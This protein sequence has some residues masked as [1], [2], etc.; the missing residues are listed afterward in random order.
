MRLDHIL[1]CFSACLLLLCC[2]GAL[3][4]AG[5]PPQQGAGSPLPVTRL[6]LSNSCRQGCVRSGERREG[7]RSTPN[8]TFSRMH[9]SVAQLH[10][11]K[12]PRRQHYPRLAAP[13]R[14]D[15]HP[16]SM[17]AATAMDNAG[18]ASS[19]LVSKTVFWLGIAFT[20]AIT[21]GML[22][23]YLNIQRGKRLERVLRMTEAKF[24]QLFNCAGDA[25]YI[26]DL[27]FRIIEVNPA[28]CKLMGYSHDQ[29][30]GLTLDRVNA[31]EQIPGTR[32]R[33]DLLRRQGS[34]LYESLQLTGGG[35][36]IPVEVSATLIEY[37]DEPAVLSIVRDISLRK[38]I[39][40]REKTRLQILEQMATGA[41]LED[42][43]AYIVRFV[44]QESPGALCS[45]LL[46]N[47][48]G[49]QLLA[50]AAPSLP[51]SYNRAVN[52]LRIKEGMGSCG[53]AAYL[54]QRVIVADIENHPYWKGFQPARD[55]GLRACWSEPVLSNEGELLGTF[56]VY[57]R[58]C[59]TPSTEELK[60]IESAAHMSSIAI[61]RVRS[62]ESRS[63]L[64]LQMRQMQKIEAVGQ[65]AAGLAHDFNN[66][67]TPIFVYADMVRRSLAED[68]PNRNRMAGIVSSAGKAANLTRQ[69]LSFG[70][71]QI[72]KKENLELNEVIVSLA[73]LLQR[74]IRA[75]VDLRTNLTPSGTRVLADRGQIE[76]ILVNLAVNAQDA[77]QGNGQ[78]IIETA[79][80]VLD[81]EFAKLNPGVKTG[82]HILLTF[83]DDGCGMSEEV[84]QHMFEP[85]YTTKSQGSGTG[86]G[87]A[88]VYGIVKQHNGYI[89][90]QS[91]VGAGTSLLIYLP[92]HEQEAVP[93]Q[94]V[95]TVSPRVPSGGSDAAILVVDDNQPIREMAAELLASAGYRVLVAETPAR[96]R[97]MVAARGGSLD[98]LVTDVVMPQMSGPELYRELAQLCPGL[99]VLYI[100]GYTFD[101][102]L[103]DGSGGEE[104]NFLPK[105]FNC[106]QLLASVRQ[107]L[108]TI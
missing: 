17:D 99:S 44:E 69:L 91:R 75:N 24:R 25:I 9:P 10:A 23:L 65:L 59:R 1:K 35:E 85:F 50:G 52:G 36:L 90:V 72:L 103:H 22:V 89:K 97:E 92:R 76:Q 104:A 88:T 74:T 55:A 47:E 73:D 34:A 71:K 54:R 101:L 106:E 12:F 41:S 96:A 56:A 70:R 78:I 49:T 64:E 19:Y 94:S 86:L 48:A 87:L 57:Y 93:V 29:L 81:R 46:A 42:L 66:L 15:Y 53:T 16:R 11:G 38:S 20:A 6:Q 8:G 63:R 40:L 84:L 80:V 13:C 14:A 32:E 108:K 7:L 3:P 26:H 30:L 60:L 18:P 98:L 100:S 61:G 39:E 31:P 58:S 62:D 79:N 102:K 28:A 33:V 82:P 43:L 77:I 5:T 51:A 45:V 2:P 21:L 27:E 105:P 4:F 83:S 95:E 37:E 68:D 107:T 67:L